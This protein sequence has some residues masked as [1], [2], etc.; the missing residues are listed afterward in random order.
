MVL[1][2]A[3]AFSLVLVAGTTDGVW[4]AVSG[5]RSLCFTLDEECDEEYAWDREAKNDGKKGGKV[6][7]ASLVDCNV[8]RIQVLCK[9]REIG[10]ERHGNS[11]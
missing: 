5:S 9:S 7:Q 6:G 3:F 8:G 2:A 11:H 10:R 1:T 4:L